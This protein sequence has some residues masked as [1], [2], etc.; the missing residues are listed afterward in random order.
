MKTAVDLLDDLNVA[1]YHDPG[2]TYPDDEPYSPHIRYPEYPLRHTIYEQNSVYDAVRQTLLLLNLDQKNFG[3]HKWNPFKE[4]VHPG[5]IVVIKPNFVLDR[6]DRGGDLFSII[7]HPSVIRAVVDY[8]YIGLSGEGQIV[9]ADAP[10]MDC[11]FQSLLDRTKLRSIQELYKRE[12]GFDIEIYDLRDFWYDVKKT[13][14]AKAAYTKHRFKLPGDPQGHLVVPLDKASLFNSADSQSFYGADYDRR[15]VI[16]HHHGE[17]HKYVMSRTILSADA[18][19]FVPKLKVH[20]KVGVT[21]NVKGLVGAVA[22]KN[23]LVHYRLGMPSEGGDQFPEYVLEKKE[24]VAVKLQRWASDTFL[25]HRHLATDAMYDC[26][27]EVASLTLKRLGFRLESEKRL[28]DAGNWHG[29]DTAWRMAVDLYHIFLYAD[30]EGLLDTKPARR[31]FSI[32][33]GVTAGEGDGPLI[34][35]SKKCGVIVAGFNSGAVDIAGARLMGFDYNKIKMLSY[36]AANSDKFKAEVN[37]IRIE[38]NQDEYKAL[39]HPDNRKRY[40]DFKPS[41]G[42]EGA[43]EI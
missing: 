5:D 20:K 12:L 7:T 4:I 25:S 41:H 34:P 6:H 2:L 32:I 24:Q 31:L 27:S 13:E 23:C 10:Q 36:L 39:L 21:L 29:N 26:I 17:V 40:F 16:R 11:D 43:I 35:A 15:E 1:I 3:T 9:I 18:V 33:D 42:W 37:S 19:I 8:V 22:N 28:L 30:K 38:S 14:G